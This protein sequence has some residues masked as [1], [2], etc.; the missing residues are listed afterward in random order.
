MSQN[1][2]DN[3]CPHSSQSKK[4]IHFA[5]AA[6]EYTNVVGE[7]VSAD[8]STPLSRAHLQLILRE[9]KIIPA[10]KES[11]RVYRGTAN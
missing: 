10:T 11:C 5:V 8:D 6:H 3:K 4:I 7:H 9:H 1:G 2:Q